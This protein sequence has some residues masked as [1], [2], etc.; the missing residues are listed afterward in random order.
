MVWLELRPGLEAAK[1]ETGLSLAIDNH[2]VVPVVIKN[3]NLA[4]LY[5]KTYGCG[6]MAWGVGIG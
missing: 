1:N 3:P 4:N 2:V 5:V 6:G